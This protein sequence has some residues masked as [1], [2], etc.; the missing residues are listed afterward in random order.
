MFQALAKAGLL[1]AVPGPRGGYRLKV[2]AGRIT[3][4]RLIEAVDGPQALDG[5]VLGL[6][7]CSDEKPCALHPIWKR[8]KD[9][10]LPALNRTTLADVRRS[11]LKKGVSL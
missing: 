9:R 10:L 1:E 8:T 3:L 4:Q 11:A 6:N 5:C 7:R 2:A